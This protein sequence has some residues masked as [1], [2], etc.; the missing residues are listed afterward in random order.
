ML[1][2]VQMHH[3]V[4]PS[5]FDAIP[6]HLAHHVGHVRQQIPG[7]PGQRYLPIR[8]SVPIR[9]D[10]CQQN[11]TNFPLRL[12]GESEH[13]LRRKTPNGTVD[14]GFDGTP[15]QPFIGPPAL[16]HVI[17][18]GPATVDRSGRHP[19]ISFAA[20]RNDQR[21]ASRSH[22]GHKRLL[23]QPESLLG[24]PPPTDLSSPCFPLQ[25]VESHIDPESPSS[26]SQRT[27]QGSF[28]FSSTHLPNEHIRAGYSACLPPN[29]LVP[30]QLASSPFYVSPTFLP[31]W[32]QQTG[33]LR[34][35]PG[36]AA[37]L[38]PSGLGPG[39]V[40]RHA[41]FHLASDHGAES[42]SQAQG[43]AGSILGHPCP[44]LDFREKMLLSAHQAYV[45]LLAHHHHTRRPQQLASSNQN[46]VVAKSHV[47]P[48]PP[49]RLS[50]ISW[51]PSTPQSIPVAGYPM[52]HVSQPLVQSAIS[53]LW[54]DPAR[55]SFDSRHPW[56]PSVGA[57]HSVQRPFVP[58][59]TQSCPT[60]RAK[61]SLERLTQLCEQGGW[62]W[63]EG[64]VLAG[65][66]Q[67][68]L[69]QFEL[70]LD[71]FTRAAALDAR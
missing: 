8:T 13:Q 20:A 64:L 5:N 1:P 27:E 46:G 29:D 33:Y 43:S 60:S 45:D 44:V 38:I 67:F 9:P 4:H 16:K 31:S 59:N 21:A 41:G 57:E 11:P 36:S 19:G 63:T 56:H 47:F 10:H 65:C 26:I 58:Y 61:A 28:S 14:A 62:Q 32:S 23:N 34:T 40:E 25:A 70:A 49:I 2:L 50:R 53:N 48:K 66:L 42:S 6:S 22:L 37:P 12:L 54:Q 15:A 69:D 71:W 18:S 30:R 7:L 55:S 17:L 68:G 52:H 3:M 35:G 24:Y 51:Q 39:G